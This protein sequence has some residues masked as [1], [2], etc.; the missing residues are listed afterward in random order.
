MSLALA[1]LGVIALVTFGPANNPPSRDPWQKLHRPIRIP[2]IAP[3]SPC[4]LSAANGSMPSPFVG[5]AFG[6][7]PAY[8]G[9]RFDD[10]RPVLRYQDPIS[11]QSGFY[12]SGWF[13]QKVLWVV[14]PRYRGR[15]LIRGKQLDGPFLVRFQQ[16]QP[17]KR[18]LRVVSRGRPF[19]TDWPSQTRVRAPGCYGY[20]VDGTSFSYVIV[21]E[22][23]PFGAP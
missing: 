23:K 13:G 20:Q 9:M 21:F 15:V 11:S 14:A 3:G 22:A 17:P 7:G 10:T 5:T 12:G 4:P 19:T 18:E 16:G 2:H 1:A 8:P 6:P